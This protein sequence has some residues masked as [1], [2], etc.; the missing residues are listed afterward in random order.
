[1]NS[2]SKIEQIRERIAEKLL[3]VATIVTIPAAIFSAFRIFSMGLKPLFI[4]DIV[5]SV[6]LVVAYL[7]RAYIDYKK[8]VLGLIIYVFFLGTLALYTWGLFGLGFFMLFFTCILITTL[9][10]LRYG[11]YLLILSVVVILIFTISVYYNLIS[12]SADFNALSQNTFQWSSRLVFFITFSSIAIVTLGLVYQNLDNFNKEISESENRFRSLFENANDAIFIVNEDTIFDCNPKTLELFKCSKD[13]IVGMAAYELSPLYQPDGLGSKEKAI[14]YLRRALLGVPQR[15]EW[16]HCRLDGSQFDVEVS[17]NRIELGD[18]VF[19]QAI[20]RDITDR[21]LFEQ[22][23]L[24][25]EME[26][27]EKERL[28]LAGDLHDDVGPL[29]SSLNMYLSLVEREQT[30]NKKELLQTMQSILKDTITSVREISNN[31]SPHILNNYGL[32]S[33]IH[34]FVESKQKLIKINFE[35]TIGTY[36]LPRNIELI[37]YRLIKELLNN[38]LKYANANS[39]TICIYKNDNLVHLIYKDDGVGFDSEDL[40]SH[41]HSG[42]GLLNIINRLNTL[43]ANYILNSK[44]GKGFNFE[45]KYNLDNLL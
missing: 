5:V 37:C 3:L 17:L 40:L 21:K 34:A 23:V 27:E 15:F 22:R 1:M 6:L 33:A 42:I 44:P 39:T 28:K 38:T 31:L 30:E 4:A 18:S 41:E 20:T 29:L 43:N 35:E 11:I 14:E 9:F 32:I 13:H 8:R 12:W 26:S 10:G 19:V 36:R 2:N 16:R 24:K 25:A 7:T 45:M